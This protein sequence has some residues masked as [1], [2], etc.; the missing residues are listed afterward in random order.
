MILPV[1][2][3]E[4]D[5]LVVALELLGASLRREEVWLRITEVEAYRWPGDSA[6]HCRAGRTERNAPMWGPAGRVYVYQCYGIHQ[7]LNLVTGAPGQGAAV[8]IRAAEPEAG[9]E[10][11]RAR[12]GGRKGPELLA[13]PGRVGQALALD[14]GWCDHP[15]TEAGG[16]EVHAGTPP[17]RIAVGPRVGVDYADPMDR[18]A[19]YR[20]ADA[21]SAYVSHP[22]RLHPEAGGRAHSAERARSVSPR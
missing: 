11:V 3:Y 4:R 12:R 15:V 21:E 8:L 18:D 10:R 13:G 7:L 19:L 6:N 2:F 1:S 17:R 22:K 9:L 16:L 5:A 14:T 20:L